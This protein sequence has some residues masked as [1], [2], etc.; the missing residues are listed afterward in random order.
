MLTCLIA[1]TLQRTNQTFLC[2]TNQEKKKKKER[3]KRVVGAIVYTPV[4][5]PTLSGT[6]PPCT[7]SILRYQCG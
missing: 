5:E 1:E 3:E 7:S 4:I 6:K 2:S